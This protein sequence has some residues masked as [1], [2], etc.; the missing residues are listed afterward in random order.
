MVTQ[1]YIFII[2]ILILQISNAQE[3][4]KHVAKNMIPQFVAA[5]IARG[6]DLCNEMQPDQ[7]LEIE[8]SIF[9]KKK[10]VIHRMETQGIMCTIKES[11]RNLNCDQVILKTEINKSS[12]ECLH[13]EDVSRIIPFR[14]L[15]WDQ[16]LEIFAQE[17]FL[18]RSFAKFIEEDRKAR[19]RREK[20]ERDYIEEQNKI[21]AWIERGYKSEEQY[22]REQEENQR[23]NKFWW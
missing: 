3:F 21:N 18:K 4:D 1:S 13:S 5:T 14:T 9:L 2:T 6:V 16:D 7:V 17:L 23:V 19:I 20:L 10:I 11:S 8:A 22:G 12:I 15:R